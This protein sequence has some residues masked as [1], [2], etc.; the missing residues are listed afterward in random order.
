MH[1]AWEE[2][3][4]GMMLSWALKCVLMRLTLHMLE[5][6][7]P[8]TLMHLEHITSYNGRDSSVQQH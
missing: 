2:S 1:V 4:L 7:L 5:Q 3:N 6:L 8:F